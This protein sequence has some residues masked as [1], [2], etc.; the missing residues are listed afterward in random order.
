MDRNGLLA[1]ALEFEA[2]MTA[3]A[4]DSNIVSAKGIVIEA[5]HFHS[6]S[7]YG[8]RIQRG[9]SDIMVKSSQFS[10]NSNPVTFS[11]RSRR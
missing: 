10:G 1:S 5:S 8:I 4:M 3:T 6:H 2:S 9:R 7:F 11:A